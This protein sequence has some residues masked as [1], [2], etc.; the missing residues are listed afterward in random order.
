MDGTCGIYRRALWLPCVLCVVFGLSTVQA[1]TRK[2]VNHGQSKESVIKGGGSSFQTPNGEA[3]YYGRDYVDQHTAG[4]RFTTNDSPGSSPKQKITVKPTL[5]VNPRNAA[6]A[7]I[8]GIRG[9][10]P[11]VVASA[12]ATAII[13]AIDG[14]IDDGVVKVPTTNPADPSALGSEHY[15]WRPAS[16]GYYPSPDSAC[17]A[18]YDSTSN[19]A[20]YTDTRVSRINDEAYRCEGFHAPHN[21]WYYDGNVL[22][23]GSSCPD[24]YQYD[25]ALASCVVNVWASPSDADWITAE[26][27][28]SV[29]DSDFVRDMVRASCEGSN[30]PSRC[31]DEM[32]EWGDLQGPAQQTG[33]KVTSTTTSTDSTGVATST[34][35]TVQN[36][37]NYTFG[38]N[39]Y[40]YSTTTTETKSVNGVQVSETVTTE[41]ESDIDSPD[42]EE[43][44]D[45]FPCVGDICN[46]P[47]YQDQY[48]PL[49]KTK[50]DF[51]DSYSARV[52]SL[53]IIQAVGGLFDVS[54]DGSCPV[55]NFSHQLQIL[56]SSV[57]INL[58][59]DYLCLPWFVQYGPWIRAIIYLVAV[60]GAI[61]IALL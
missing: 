43:R 24:G 36:K 19:P 30:A 57:S 42:Q 38:P 37:Y 11:G 1:A 4:N 22:R 47:A 9:G 40:N 33:P 54:V 34:T 21:I 13:A 55:W 2:I 26:D 50:E 61:R 60:Y 32:S 14:V 18:Y 49:D 39:Y 15:R 17:R 27:W 12:A 46:G 25:S 8:G 59:F 20:N 45:A 29:R 56:G 51:L 10:V 5:K 28:A 48:A 58:T 16:A 6:K 52:A 3:G 7:V 41:P 44:D 31:Y 35:T 23:S 53:P